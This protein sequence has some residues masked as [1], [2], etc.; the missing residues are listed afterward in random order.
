MSRLE[1][2]QG[3]GWHVIFESTQDCGEAEGG[4]YGGSVELDV[5]LCVC[6]VAKDT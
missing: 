6:L 2:L 3:K 1:G 4:I 5:V